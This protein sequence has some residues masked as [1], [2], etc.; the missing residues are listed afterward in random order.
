MIYILALL[1]C[2]MWFFSVALNCK[3]YQP[4]RAVTWLAF[5]I[6]LGLALAFP[7]AGRGWF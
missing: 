6:L 4:L 3:N 7:D 5:C 1:I 2:T